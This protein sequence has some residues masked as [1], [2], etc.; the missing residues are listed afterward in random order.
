MRQR[1]ALQPG[2]DVQ[3]KPG[4]GTLRSTYR[5]QTSLFNSFYSVPLG[6]KTIAKCNENIMRTQ[7]TGTVKATTAAPRKTLREKNSSVSQPCSTSYGE[8]IKRTLIASFTLLTLKALDINRFITIFELSLNLKFC[9]VIA[10]VLCVIGSWFA[11]RD[12]KLRKLGKQ[13]IVWI[14]FSRLEPSPTIIP[15]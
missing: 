1:C 12:C 5:I 3:Q 9:A 15:P 7:A 2:L 11:L 6:F 13:A 10:P 8:K 14:L 4:T